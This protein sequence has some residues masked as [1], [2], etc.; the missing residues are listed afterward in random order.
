VSADTTGLLKLLD[1]YGAE[2]YAL[3]TRMTLRAGVAE[4]LLQDLFLKLRQAEGLRRATDPKA[5]LFRAAIHLACDWRRARRETEPLRTELPQVDESPLDRL[6]DWEEL[7]QVLD[8]LPSLSELNRQVL[9]LRYLQHQEYD[10]IAR[11]LGKTNH[12][13][14]GL[15]AKALSQ[16]RDMLQPTHSSEKGRKRP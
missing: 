2:L 6:I 4:D 1:L 10:D 7:E 5:Y 3:F 11:Q 16:L 9:L 15:C 12:Q 13:V 8:A 14:R